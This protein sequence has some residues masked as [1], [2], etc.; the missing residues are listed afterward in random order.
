MRQD[1]MKVKA[2]VVVLAALLAVL[3]VFMLCGPLNSPLYGS[4]TG[5][6][7]HFATQTVPGL[8]LH[9]KIHPRLPPNVTFDPGG[10]DSLVFIHIPKTGGS[11]FLRHLVT[12]ISP[13]VCLSPP[14][15]P[16]PRSLAERIGTRRRKRTKP[17]VSD[18]TAVKMIHCQSPRVDLGS[19]QRRLWVGT[20]D[21]IHSTPS[22]SLVYPLKTLWQRR[23]KGLIQLLPFTIPPCSVTQSSGTS[24]STFTCRGAPLSA[25][26]TCVVGKE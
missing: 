17:C 11:D 12:V 7:G 4:T 14:L 20:V 26:D 19:F 21:Y 13:S 1:G 6:P 24:A 22:T 3:C 5:T 2:A 8:R 16:L 9:A 18:L 15:S 23:D 10:R 25:T